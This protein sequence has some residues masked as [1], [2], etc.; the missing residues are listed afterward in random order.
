[1]P[2]IAINSL[3]VFLFVYTVLCYSDSD[4]AVACYKPSPEG[5]DS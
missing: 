5:D 2:I 3:P 4:I 1:M